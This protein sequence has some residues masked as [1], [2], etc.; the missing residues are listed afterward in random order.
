MQSSLIGAICFFSPIFSYFCLF[1]V[2]LRPCKPVPVGDNGDLHELFFGSLEM[3][4][5]R[6]G[7]AAV[8]TDKMPKDKVDHASV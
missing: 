8:V 5:N 2:A 7:S 4:C 1:V 3:S 6:T